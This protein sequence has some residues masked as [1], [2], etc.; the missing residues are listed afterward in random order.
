MVLMRVLCRFLMQPQGIRK[1]AMR[2]GMAQA[3]GIDTDVYTR[4]CMVY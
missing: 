2:Q 4:G 3:L 1:A